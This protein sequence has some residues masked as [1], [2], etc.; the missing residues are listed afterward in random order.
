MREGPGPSVKMDDNRTRSVLTPLRSKYGVKRRPGTRLSD[1]EKRQV[2]RDGNGT[3]ESDSDSTE[4]LVI[5][6]TEGQAAFFMRFMA[7]D[8][9]C[10]DEVFKYKEK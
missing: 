3:V 2:K 6:T 4:D 8:I 5:D 9:Q 1:T 7:G 10:P